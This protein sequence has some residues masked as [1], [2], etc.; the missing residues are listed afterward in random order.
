MSRFNRLKQLTG[1]SLLGGTALASEDAEGAGINTIARKLGVSLDEASKIKNAAKD[2]KPSGLQEE[3]IDAIKNVRKALSSDLT[4]IGS[5][6]DMSVFDAGD[7]V[8]KVPFR[9][10]EK[11]QMLGILEDAKSLVPGAVYGKGLGPKTKVIETNK[12]VYNVQEKIKPITDLE[13]IV[14]QDKNYQ[15]LL[16]DLGQ[17]NLGNPE[18][19]PKYDEALKKVHNRRLELLKEQGLNTDQIIENY[20]KANSVNKLKFEEQ[21]IKN[22]DDLIAN[23]YFASSVDQTL[24]AR[25]KLYPGM[26]VRD[27]HEYNVGIDK[28]GKSKIFD[29]SR[30]NEVNPAKFDESMQKGAKESYIGLPDKKQ[31]LDSLFRKAGIQEEKSL[32]SKA[33]DAISLP[34]RYMMN[35]AAEAAGLKGNLDDSEAS[36]QAL[37][38]AGAE[39]LG[40][41]EDS[42]IGNAAK[43]LGVAGLEVFADPLAA[44]AFPVKGVAS[45]IKQL[46]KVIKSTPAIES[47]LNKL[48]K[49]KE[50]G[51]TVGKQ[52]GVDLRSFD[53]LKRLLSNR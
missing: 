27:V 31:S 34:Q 11:E 13:N 35:K 32:G 22:V 5:G 43:A 12:N 25:R 50:L 29:T 41:P 40:I 9:D 51:E 36:A 15:K 19:V 28:S 30:F 33:L 47:A 37:V 6:M 44:L 17:F 52:T 1:G 20:N 42:N 8:V 21:G 26:N 23:P 10:K 7:K 24:D 3:N 2:I 14:R 49:S 45:G 18:D 46:P 48:R 39:K 53:K 16:D 38:E 4:K